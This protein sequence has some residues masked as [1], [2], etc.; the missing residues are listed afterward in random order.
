MSSDRRPREAIG[1]HLL[2][3][4]CQ[5]GDEAAFEELFDRYNARILYYL[6]RLVG[7]DG[8]AEDVMQEVWVKILRRIGTLREPRAL[9]TWLYRIAHNQAVE[10]LRKQ[11]REI[12]LEDLEEVPN[13]TEDIGALDRVDAAALHRALD[14]TS[15]EHQAVLT[16]RFMNE[17]SYQEIADVTGCSLGTVKSRLHFA[18][19]ALRAEIERTNGGIR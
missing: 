18:K 5:V 13:G 12:S 9:C 15:P 6:R 3:L 2:V 10:R 19:R 16:L 4:L 17:L 14:R 7:T 8:E 11:G 1:E